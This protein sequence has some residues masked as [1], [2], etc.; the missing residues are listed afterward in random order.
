MKQQKISYEVNGTIN[1]EDMADVFRSSGIRRPVNDLER[2]GR[3]LEE[4]QLTVSAR[5]GGEL[6]GIARCLTDFSYA[7]YLSDLAVKKDHQSSG[8]GKELIDRVKQ[9]I[10]PQTALVLLSAP[11]AMDYYP[12]AGF[13]K[14]ENGF[15]VKREY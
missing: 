15:I 1:P 5:V 14:V 9:A 4:A 2:M 8:I 3:M 7:C 6:V 11:E 10:G 13:E 12:K